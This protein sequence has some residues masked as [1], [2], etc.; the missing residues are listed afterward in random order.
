MLCQHRY[1][2]FWKPLGND[3]VGDIV[4]EGDIV[5]DIVAFTVFDFGLGR[6]GPVVS[7]LAFTI[8]WLGR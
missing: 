8:S 3:I 2:S 5:G 6:S 1:G 4:G 7:E